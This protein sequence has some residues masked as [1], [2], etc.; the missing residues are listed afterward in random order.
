VSVL[1]DLL[2]A[3]R[4]GES[5][6]LVMRGEPGVGKTALLDD[7]ARHATGCRVVRA[8][9]VQSEMEFA[10]GGLH[11]LL[12]P[13]LDQL[14]RLPAPQ[15]EALRTVFGISTGPAPDR[16]LVALAVLSML[17][18]AA[19]E[20]PLVCVVDDEQWLDEASAQALGF[21]ARRLAADP[22]GLVFGAR[23]PGAALAANRRCD[24]FTVCEDFPC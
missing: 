19:A 9:G 23:I 8:A 10:F 16:F 18:E 15:Q 13:L 22:V 5:Q 14:E 24:F 12:V 4:A 20:R 6:V 7:M 2:A 1:A 11:Q 21:A 17:A 3:V